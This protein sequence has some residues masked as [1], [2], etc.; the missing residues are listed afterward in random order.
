M[1]YLGQMIYISGL[2]IAQNNYKD[3]YEATVNK[4]IQEQVINK[5]YFSRIKKEYTG[6][7]PIMR[8]I[9]EYNNKIVDG[10]F[11]AH[12]KFVDMLSTK[13]NFV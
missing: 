4:I 3:T 1:I 5:K 11:N 8:L 9:T 13:K 6:I 10:I 7:N 2:E 12:R